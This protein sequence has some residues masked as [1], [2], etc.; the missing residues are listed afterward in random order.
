MPMKIPKAMPAS[1]METLMQ[2]SD[3]IMMFCI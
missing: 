2:K 1:A 3:L